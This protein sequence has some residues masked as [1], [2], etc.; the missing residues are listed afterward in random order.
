[1]AG[2]KTV[3][4]F[5]DLRVFVVAAKL[6]SLSKAAEYLEIAQPAL[7]RRLKRLELR[8]GAELM[9][10]SARGVFLTNHG[11]RLFSQVHRLVDGV[12][13]VER[14]FALQ[15]GLHASDHRS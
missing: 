8:I 15:V 11:S 6:G 13:E 3:L 5:D 4:V 1:M 10:R 14:N 12:T 9:T 7:S 2:M